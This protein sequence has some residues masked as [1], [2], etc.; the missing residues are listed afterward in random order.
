MD[1]RY[2]TGQETGPDYPGH[3]PSVG[4]RK[5]PNAGG[6]DKRET[7]SGYHKSGRKRSGT[8]HSDRD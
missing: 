1:N 3:N 7:P 4:S 2:G 8:Q 5:S 6:A